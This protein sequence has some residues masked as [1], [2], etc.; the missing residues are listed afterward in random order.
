MSFA[1]RKI[2]ARILKSH[3]SEALAEQGGCCRYCMAPLTISQ[4]TADHRVPR[5]KGGL[6]VRANIIAA[7]QP[8]NAAKGSLPVLGFTRMLKGALP[9]AGAPLSILMAWSRR[10]IWLATHRACRTIRYSA[11]LENNTPVGKRAA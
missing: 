6:N 7:C 8:C 9:P 10:R 11:G 1:Y 4:A 5:S 3:K 2:E